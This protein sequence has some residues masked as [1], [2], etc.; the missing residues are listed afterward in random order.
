MLIKTKDDV[1]PALKTLEDLLATPTLTREQKERIEDEISHI[2]TGARGEKEAAYHIDFRLKDAQNY[3][4]VHDLRLEHNGRV[5]QIDHLLVG[6]FFDI[7]LIE[8]KRI[9]TGIRVNDNGEFEVKTRFGWRGM[10]S[11]V[12]QSKRHAQVLGEL[13]CEHHLLPTRLGFQIR[14]TFHH[15]I[16]V[17]PE[18]HI[19]RQNQEATIVKMDLFGR[20]MNHWIERHAGSGLL[21]MAKTVSKETLKAFAGALVARHQ[22]ISMNFAAKFGVA[23]PTFSPPPPV[24]PTVSEIPP[25]EV[26]PQATPCEKCGTALE[27]RVIAFC[28]ANS[29]RFKGGLFCRQCQP[30]LKAPPSCNECGVAV[31]DKVVAFCRFNRRRFRN[32]L[33][34]RECQPAATPS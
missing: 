23:E 15:W 29:G 22:P 12:E 30:L 14:P 17:P 28:R 9:A 34:C 20:H 26:P 4:V 16:L 32:R 27:E 1:E 3:M 5:A 19:V 24:A 33:L 25:P 21:A 7:I 10:V 6:R 11:P 31:D 13:A 2:R 18:C 8:S